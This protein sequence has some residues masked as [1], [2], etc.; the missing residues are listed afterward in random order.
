MGAAL[1]LGAVLFF[2]VGCADLGDLSLSLPRDD[3]SDLLRGCESLPA[4]A[5]PPRG[6]IARAHFRF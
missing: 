5:C 1:A 6:P 2:L 4:S 3:V